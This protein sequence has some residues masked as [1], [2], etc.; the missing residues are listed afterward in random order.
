MTTPR[1]FKIPPAAVFG[2][3]GTVFS[4]PR[5]IAFVLHRP[6][7]SLGTPD[8]NTIARPTYR[9]RVGRQRKEIRTL[10]RAGFGSA[11]P[12]ALL[13]RMLANIDGLVAEP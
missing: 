2:I 8:A 12:E 3:S 4:R 10:Q 9:Y 5:V 1:L 6:F 13:Q 11:P 7:V